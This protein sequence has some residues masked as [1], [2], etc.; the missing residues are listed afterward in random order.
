[1]WD[2]LLSALALVLVI[3][4]VFPFLSPTGFRQKIRLISEMDDGQVRV[5]GLV[6]MA[7]GLLLLYLIR[8]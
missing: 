7:I 5:A 8:Q 3:E 4:G 1:M 2:D 6:S